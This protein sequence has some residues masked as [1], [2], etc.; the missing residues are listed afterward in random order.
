V[1]T[2]QHDGPLMNQVEPLRIGLQ[3][4]D[5]LSLRP[6]RRT[7]PNADDYWD[8]NWLK[9]DVEVRAGAFRCSLEADL[10]A[11]DF[12]RLRGDL[13]ALYTALKGTAVLK[14]LEGWVE[15]TIVGDGKGHLSASCAVMD[16]PG[17]GNRLTFSLSFDQTDVPPMLA[18]LSA[19]MEAF[20]VKAAEE[21]G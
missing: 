15:V 19:I 11:D 18:A 10:R 3:A 5:H 7:H 13:A 21:R 6:T 20:P 8:G 14:T 4:G 16:A 2:A 1:P 12:H 9:V 17:I